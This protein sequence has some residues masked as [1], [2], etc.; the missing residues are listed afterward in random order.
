[1]AERGD[2]RLPLRGRRAARRAH[3]AVRP[4]LARQPVDGV[5]AVGDG[6]AEDVVVAL[7]EEVP[8]LVLHDVRVAPLDRGQR[9]GHVG[10]DAVAHV[11]VVEVVGRLREHDR[12]WSRWRPSAGRCRWPGARRRASASSPCARR[13]RWTAVRLRGRVGAAARPATGPPCCAVSQ[14]A[15]VRQPTRTVRTKRRD[16][17]RR[18]GIMSAAPCAAR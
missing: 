14:V 6:R 2:R 11:P 16:E 4:R 10:G 9:R 8:A 7:G 15:V 12:H 3:L 13:W 17:E 1:M 5:V 18:T